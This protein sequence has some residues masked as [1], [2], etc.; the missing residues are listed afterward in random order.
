MRPTATLC[1]RNES[2]YEILARLLVLSLGLG[3]VALSGIAFPRVALTCVGIALSGITFSRVALTRV[4]IALGG[5]GL[6]LPR[7]RLQ[8][9]WRQFH[10]AGGDSR[11]ARRRLEV[12]GGRLLQ[13]TR[14]GL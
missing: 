12:S 2:E 7:R 10:L 1:L 6:Y 14:R 13:V 11:M 9:T 8:L 3:R 4:G 5:R